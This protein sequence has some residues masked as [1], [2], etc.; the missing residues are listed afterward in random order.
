MLLIL[1]VKLC[2]IIGS[3]G[4]GGGGGYIIISKKK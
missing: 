3:V 2:E 1:V 4:G